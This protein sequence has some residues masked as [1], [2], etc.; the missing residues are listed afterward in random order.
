VTSQLHPLHVSRLAALLLVL[1]GCG[2]RHPEVQTAPVPALPLPTAGI[3]GQ[4]VSVY[5]VTLLS[6]EGTLGWDSL[7][8]PRPA[9][10]ARADSII[11]ALLEERSP[12]VKWVLPPALRRAAARAPSM[13]G[14]PDRMGTA[15][16]RS[17]ELKQIPDP[18]R[19]QMRTLTA[20]AGG[21]YALVPAS[22]LFYRNPDGR[23]RAEL[24][25]VIADVRTGLI[26]W[27]TMAH[28]VGDDPWTALRDAFKTLT[29]GV[30]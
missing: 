15:L 16:L 9:A 11:A 30:P 7:V 23:G 1:A 6:A 17:T 5:P 10:L 21:R 22:L 24:T 2:G 19:S 3:A 25:L 18:L 29:P 12:E 8:G 28:A 13:L 14:D 26:E 27:R 20:V 4:D